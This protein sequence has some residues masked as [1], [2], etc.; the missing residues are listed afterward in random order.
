[1]TE[2]KTI[3]FILSSED[4]DLIAWKNSLPKRAFNRTVNPVTKIALTIPAAH[5]SKPRGG[6]KY[7][8]KIR[9]CRIIKVKIW[10]NKVEVISID[11]I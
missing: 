4:S 9:L 1:M 7:E 8:R 6:S 11:A 3:H 5:R 10:K 2:K